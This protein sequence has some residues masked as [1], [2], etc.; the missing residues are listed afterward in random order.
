MST[1]L[2]FVF[3][4]VATISEL[5]ITPALSWLIQQDQSSIIWQV[6]E[7]LMGH[8]EMANVIRYLELAENDLKDKLP[9]IDSGI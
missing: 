3:V 4:F 7:I 1:Q 6:K 5:L 8:E 9:T 2:L